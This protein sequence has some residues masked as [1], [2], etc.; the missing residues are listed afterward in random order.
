[1]R[2]ISSSGRLFSFYS[3]LMVTVLCI[4]LPVGWCGEVVLHRGRKLRITAGG[5]AGSH[6]QEV[7]YIDEA[8]LAKQL[9]IDLREVSPP[10]SIPDAVALT[11]TRLNLGRF[12]ILK[13]ELV[14]HQKEKSGNLL[15][16]V[17]TYVLELYSSDG[18][19]TYIVLMDGSL[20]KPR[21]EPIVGP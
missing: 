17:F 9:P 11:A 3:R 16:G 1:M 14:N 19:Q 7:F 21:K 5:G 18:I 15:K 8:V 10:I 2:L 6:F 4:G 20:V 12:V 13:T